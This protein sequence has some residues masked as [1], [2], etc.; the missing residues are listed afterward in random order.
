MIHIS[1][2]MVIV[3][4]I[5]FVSLTTDMLAQSSRTVTGKLIDSR[6]RKG[7]SNVSI[8]L[9][10]TN[11]GT[12]TNKEG[13]FSFYVPDEGKA[14]VVFSTLG[15]TSVSMPLDSLNANKNIVRLEK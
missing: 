12:V 6:N 3:L 2:Y 8:S 13:N 15:Y 1:R 4:S 14:L 9:K 7:L 5:I 11:I 10:G